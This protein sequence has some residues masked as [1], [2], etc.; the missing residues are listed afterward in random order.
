MKIAIMEIENTDTEIDETEE[1]NL[2][3][4]IMEECKHCGELHQL[5]LFRV[6]VEGSSIR[7]LIKALRDL[8]TM[9]G[10]Y[11]TKK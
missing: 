4:K 6:P 1:T 8:T 5:E 10:E 7:Q 2:V 3:S 11:Q 9:L